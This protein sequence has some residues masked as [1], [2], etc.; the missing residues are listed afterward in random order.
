MFAMVKVRER[1]A[2]YMLMFEV[3][4]PDVAATTREISAMDMQVQ[5]HTRVSVQAACVPSHTR[6]DRSCLRAVCGTLAVTAAQPRPNRDHGPWP[7]HCGG[8]AG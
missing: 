2:P 8:G 3:R 5:R 4:V 1:G 7:A 6:A